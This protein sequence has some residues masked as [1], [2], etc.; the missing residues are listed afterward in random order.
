MTDKARTPSKWVP[1]KEDYFMGLLMVATGAC[2][3]PISQQGALV[4]DTKDRLVFMDFNR[5]VPAESYNSVNKSKISW[6]EREVSLT[7]AIDNIADHLITHKALFNESF[8]SFC[9]YSTCYL[10]AREVVR[11]AKIG[12]KDIIYFPNEPDWFSESEYRKSKEFADVYGVKMKGFR[13][14]IA[15]VRDRILSLSYLF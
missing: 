3:D 8:F 4:T 12:I 9:V 14:N 15:W 7:T 13:G 1:S 10:S 2:K 6:D 11:C 5:L